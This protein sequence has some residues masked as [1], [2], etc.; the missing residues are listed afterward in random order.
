MHKLL[1]MGMAFIDLGMMKKEADQPVHG[2]NRL[3]TRLNEW[4]SSN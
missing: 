1:A 4:H 2:V 3:I